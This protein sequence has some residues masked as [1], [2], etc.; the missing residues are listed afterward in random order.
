MDINRKDIFV[1]MFMLPWKRRQN[2]DS[3]EKYF[4]IAIYATS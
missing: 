4:V 2:R 1:Q 3:Y